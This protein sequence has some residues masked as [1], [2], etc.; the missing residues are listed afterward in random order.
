MSLKTEI[1]LE[2]NIARKAKDKLRL[3]TLSLVINKI[4]QYEINNK[5]DL[6]NEDSIVLSILDKMIKERKESISMFEGGGRQELADKEASEI[7]FI[8]FFLPQALT[9]E[10][11]RAIVKEAVD[12]V[13]PEVMKDMGK[14]MAIVKPKVQGRGDIG[15]ASGLV[16]KS[17]LG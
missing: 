1:Q 2:K 8:Q 11:V 3:S 12:I 9:E 13:K 15:F 7:V 14:V 17:I 4:Q 10:E 6:S 16:K 5:T